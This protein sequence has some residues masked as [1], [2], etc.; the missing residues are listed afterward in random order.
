MKNDNPP[1]FT[2]PNGYRVSIT[3]RND[4]KALISKDIV[5][6][7]PDEGVNS[8]IRSVIISASRN[9]E[10]IRIECTCYNFKIKNRKII[11]DV[12]I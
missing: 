10:Y 1:V 8:Q 4:P 2:I 11:S 5:A 3:E 12:Q 9:F 7:D 6:I